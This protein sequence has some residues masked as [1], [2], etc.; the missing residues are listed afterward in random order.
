MGIKGR[1]R[2][3]VDRDLLPDRQKND[4]DTQAEL[5]QRLKAVNDHIGNSE[6]AK[7][8]FSEVFADESKKV[9]KV[10]ISKPLRGDVGDYSQSWVKY[11][12]KDADGKDQ[13]HLER[14]NSSDK[15]TRLEI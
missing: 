9:E 6:Q 8:D 5:E 7:S 3:N 2:L 10:G 1:K 13:T 11:T 4:A 12:A 15:S 14:Y